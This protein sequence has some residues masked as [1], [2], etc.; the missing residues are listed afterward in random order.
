MSNKLTQTRYVRVPAEIIVEVND[1]QAVRAAAR[2]AV[3]AVTDMPKE[4]REEALTRIADEDIADAVALIVDLA[5]LL[6]DAPGL[7][8]VEVT[9]SA[10][11]DPDYEPIDEDL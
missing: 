11:E 7:E 1:P 4:E 8:V 5:G 10:E 6:A 3:D 2:A 9:W